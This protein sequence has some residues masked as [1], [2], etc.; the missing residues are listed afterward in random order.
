MTKSQWTRTSAFLNL[1]GS[2]LVFLSFRPTSTRLM[3]VTSKDASDKTVAFCIAD[4]AVLGLGADG[5]STQMGFACPTNGNMKPTVVA[6]GDAPWMAKAGWL[7]LLIGFCVQA[8][9]I[10]PSKLTAEDLRVLRKAHKL[11]EPE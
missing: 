2:L 10:E 5:L 8:F 1:A 3:L 7:L 4:R 11:L 9:S 6:N